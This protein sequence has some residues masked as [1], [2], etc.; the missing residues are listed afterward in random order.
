MEASEKKKLI[1]IGNGM[2][3]YKFCALFVENKL[4]AEYELVVIGEE[5]RPAYDRVHLTNYYK[6][7]PAEQLTLAPKEWYESNGIQLLMSELVINIDRNNKIVTTDQHR[8]LEY[9]ILVIA[10]GSAA[11][12]PP[13]DGIHKKGVFAYRKLQ[14][15]DAIKE[16]SKT[17]KKAVVIGGGL[18][19]LE[20]AKALKNDGLDITIVEQGQRLMVRQIDDKGAAIIHEQ[21]ENLHIEILTGTITSEILGEEHVTGL[22]FCKRIDFTNRNDCNFG[23]GK[24]K[25]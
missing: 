23:R 14:D 5:N 13:I 15:L 17:V 19:G 8:T 4:G 3:G 1:V 11:Y 21:L 18:L 22:R 20:A 10:T 25:R 6:G 2:A 9:D 7:T 24:T 12:M 16:Y